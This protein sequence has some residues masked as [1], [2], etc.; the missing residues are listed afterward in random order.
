MSW[1]TE[2]AII[3]NELEN[4]QLRAPKLLEIHFC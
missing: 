3:L 4:F 1:R 2:V